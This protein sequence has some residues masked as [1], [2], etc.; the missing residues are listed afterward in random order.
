MIL[1]AAVPQSEG[2][3]AGHL[4]LAT[5][6]VLVA[7]V[8]IALGEQLKTRRAARSPRSRRTPRPL[9]VVA[10]T[11][12]AAGATHLAVAPSHWSGAAVYGAFFLLA[13][14]TQVVWSALLMVRPSRALLAL[15]AA[16]NLGL[17]ALWAQTRTLGVPLGPAAGVRERI[18]AVDLV[19]ALL[20]LS[21]AAVAL[22]LVA[23]R[24]PSARRAD[25]SSAAKSSA[26]ISAS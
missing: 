8:G 11:G 6:F 2:Q 7:L 15:T 16:V 13:G 10:A 4:L 25:W 3:H 19:C 1:S 21:S 14:S 12:A 5:G 22:H 23:Q 18:G 24:R 26:C 20:E 9:L 17:L